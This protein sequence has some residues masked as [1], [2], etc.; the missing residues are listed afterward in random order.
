M[1]A[2]AELWRAMLG[3][4]DLLT[5]RPEAGDHFTLT[6]SGLVNA[7]G[8]YF[9]VVLVIIAVESY[10]GGFPGWTPVALSLLLNALLVGGVWLI[11]W[12]TARVMR[13]PALA[14]AV[15][16]TYAMAFVLALS[17]PLVHLVGGSVAVVLLGVRAFMF[18]RAAREMGKLG[19]GISAAF[20]ILSIA[21]LAAI[22]LG[23]Y[24]LTSGGQGIG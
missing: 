8:F 3:W 6:R 23:F 1:N 20:A 24:M 9:V 15:P 2:F 14:I 13:T 5:A 18:F 21:A 17:L 7:T 11:I 22:P 19:V 16:V 4:L 12:I 10:L